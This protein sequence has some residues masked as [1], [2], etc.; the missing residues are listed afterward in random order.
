M[1]EAGS[2]TLNDANV[3]DVIVPTSFP[4]LIYIQ[5]DITNL[6][7]AGD[8]FDL[9]VQVGPNGSEII[10]SWCNLTSDGAD[11]TLD[12]DTGTPQVVHI[13]QLQLLPLCVQNTEQVL[14]NYTKN[15]V[16]DRDVPYAYSICC[17]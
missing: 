10:C 8:D 7:N 12:N 14:V 2:G 9:D 16:N 4:C 1:S 13:R 3:Q 5:F 15:S 6:N 11:I 17:G